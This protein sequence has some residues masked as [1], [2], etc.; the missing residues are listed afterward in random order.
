MK[1]ILIKDVAKLGK[2]FETKDVSSGYATNMLIPNGVAIPATRDA[3]KRFELERAKAEGEK[4]VQS[5]LL[6]GN[7][8]SLD[9]V[10]LNISGKANE[11]GHLFAGI[12]AEEIAKELDKQLHINIS[13]ESIVL[14]HPLKEIGDHSVIVKIEDKSTKFKVVLSAIK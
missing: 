9:G 6:M 12:H 5:E 11:K 8:K 13:A 4:K 1:V 2:K 14:P 10:T 3:M 7:L